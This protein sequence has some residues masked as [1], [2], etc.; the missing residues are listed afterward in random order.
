MD[1]VNEISCDE[2][3]ELLPLVADGVLEPD[4]EPGL[5]QHLARCPDCQRSLALHDLTT[6]ALAPNG[7]LVPA[8]EREQNEVIRLPW[9]A[10]LAGGVI[11]AAAA[12]L[13]AWSLGQADEAQ[14]SD[15][16][17]SE[18]ATQVVEVTTDADGNEIIV[19]MRDGQRVE[20]RAI[21]RGDETVGG[22]EPGGP[23]PVGL[24]R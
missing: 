21:D 10:A 1:P 22:S 18:P 9:P 24:H 3:E 20:I 23:T 16:E 15:A 17:R 4:D 14:A 6:L 12:G 7:A 13:I 19:L 11:L 5:F 8:E 2:A